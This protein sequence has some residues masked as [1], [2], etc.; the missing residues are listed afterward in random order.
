MQCVR[1][2]KCYATLNVVWSWV[3]GRGSVGGSVGYEHKIISKAV[4][5]GVTN[6]ATFAKLPKDF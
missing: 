5:N 2:A 6:F 3:E 4:R 1:F